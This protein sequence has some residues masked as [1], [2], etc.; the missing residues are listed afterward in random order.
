MDSVDAKITVCAFD[1][2]SDFTKAVCVSLP[3]P[4]YQTDSCLLK[5][6]FYVPFLFLIIVYNV[7]ATFR[8]DL[9]TTLTCNF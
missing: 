5:F 2:E 6:V 8:F 1:P 3:E 9:F 4:K 7:L